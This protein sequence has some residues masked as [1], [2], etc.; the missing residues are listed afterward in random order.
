MIIPNIWENKKCSKPPTSWNKGMNWGA[1]YPHISSL[2]GP[3][4]SPEFTIDY[5]CLYVSGHVS[6]VSL[7]GA[8]PW[9]GKK[10]QIWTFGRSVLSIHDVYSDS[11]SR[12]LLHFLM[13]LNQ[14][15]IMGQNLPFRLLISPWSSFSLQKQ[16]PQMVC[17]LKGLPLGNQT[18]QWKNDGKHQ[19]YVGCFFQCHAWLERPGLSRLWMSLVTTGETSEISAIR[20]VRFHLWVGKRWKHSIVMTYI[21]QIT[22]GP[23]NWFTVFDGYTTRG[24]SYVGWFVNPTYNHS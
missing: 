3:V 12:I 11:F 9:V 1:G 8:G 13:Q 16:G 10:N 17:D 6:C 2:A 15:H 7:W 22:I 21:Q 24:P 18:W 23:P 14:N 5:L 20:R 4:R 19:P